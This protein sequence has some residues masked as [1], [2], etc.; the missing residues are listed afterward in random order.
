MYLG[1]RLVIAK[2]IERIH[3]ANLINFCIVPVEFAEVSDYDRI[4]PEDELQIEDLLEAIKGAD[5]VRIVEKSGKYE[6]VGRLLLSER[7]REILLS[8]GLLNYTR[9][10]VNG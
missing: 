8:A 4:E 5:E 2:S 9:K 6:L 7:D 3:K 1:V 10:K